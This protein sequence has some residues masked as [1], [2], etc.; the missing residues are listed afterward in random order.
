MAPPDVRVRLSAEG[1]A[2]VVSALKKIQAEAD[3]AGRKARP[4]FGG[5]NSVLA[6]TSNLLGAIGAAVSVNAFASFILGA[7][8]AT[9]ALGELSE[10][11]DASV[12]NLSALNLLA[13]TNGTSIEAV[14][15]AIGKLNKQI[16]DLAD[17]APQA[18]RNFGALGL[19]VRDFK[20]KDAAEAFELV[21]QRLVGL[22]SVARRTE[23]GMSILGRSFNDLIPL[24]DQLAEDGLARTIERARELGV[25]IDGD[26]VRATGQLNDELDL[27]KLQAQGLATQFAVGLAPAV[28][29]SAQLISGDLKQTTSAWREFGEGVGVV[30][31]T[32]VAVVSSAFDIVGVGLGQFLI[33]LD[34]TT[35]A[36]LALAKGNLKEARSLFTEALRAAQEQGDLLGKRLQARL[37]LLLNAP[38]DGGEPRTRGGGAGPDEDGEDKI[39][40][41]ADAERAAIDAEIAVMKAG[42]KLREEEEK[43]A[44]EEGLQSVSDFYRDRRRIVEDATEAEIAALLKRRALLSA[45]SNATKRRGE[46]AKIDAEI[47]KVRLEREGAIAALAAEERAAVRALAT[48]RLE[49]EKSLLES[50]GRRRE[51]E[52]AAI[53]QQIEAADLLLRKQGVA[54][55]ERIR[56]LREIRGILESTADFEEA[57]AR[58]RVLFDDLARAQ[59]E[60][61]ALVR[62]G[63]ITQLQG[64]ERVLEVQRERLEALRSVAAEIS[65]IAAATGDP[66]KIAAAK[67]FADA[68]LGIASAT[69][70]ATLTLAR[71]GDTVQQAAILELT[72]LFNDLGT[73]AKSFGELARDALLG[74]IQA[75]RNLVA[76]LL[77]AEIVRRLSGLIPGAAGGGQAKSVPRKAAG[78][79]IRGPGTGTSDSILIRVSDDEFITRAAVVRQPGVLAH[80]RDLNARGAAAL[81]SPAVRRIPRF[82]SGGM[83]SDIASGRSGGEGKTT[84]LLIDLSP[85]V[86][87]RTLESP[88]GQRVQVRNVGRQKTATRHAMGI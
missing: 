74:I 21:S 4:A 40:A 6:Q 61:E 38:T 11:L 5:F 31:K 10:K 19:R 12:E 80:L 46:E 1:V 66:D 27:L 8:K 88:E 28:A 85:D 62:S 29:Q 48:E 70:A 18:V 68:L 15:G 39:R 24:M 45:E 14:G 7:S 53:E 44:F 72:R 83:V 2:E 73:S 25:L 36:A 59:E 60:I 58:A 42:N 69:D 77:A 54:D 41:R 35:R 17:E 52:Q 55:E 63:Q 76:Q 65:R 81:S 86:I 37:D 26:M 75:V 30:M 64:Q 82:A 20:G 9:E 3:A 22:D 57:R 50:I 87:L 16:Q 32:L 67:E 51:A 49:L 47:A 33:V 78:G 71:L 43:R 56:R 79:Q 34:G 23:V 84:R 13:V